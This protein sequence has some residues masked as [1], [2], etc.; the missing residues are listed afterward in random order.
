LATDLDIFVY[1]PKCL[2]PPLRG[3]LFHLSRERFLKKQKRGGGGELLCA[4]NPK[5]SLALNKAGK[6]HISAHICPKS[7]N[8]SKLGVL[9]A[10]LHPLFATANAILGALTATKAIDRIARTGIL[11]IFQR[12]FASFALVKLLL[13]IL[14]HIFLFNF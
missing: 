14:K 1:F 13:F 4:G 9:V 3:N 2:A 10:P 6:M 8:Q 11:R 7:V 5:E 12:H